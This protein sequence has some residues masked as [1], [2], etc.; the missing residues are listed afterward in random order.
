[1]NPQDS[2]GVPARSG[3][4]RH[5]N[6]V[7]LWIGE[8]TSG[9][10]NSLATLALPLI[11]VLSLHSSTFGSRWPAS[12]AYSAACS[13]GRPSSGSAPPDRP[14]CPVMSC[15]VSA[16]PPDSRADMIRFSGRFAPFARR[17]RDRRQSEEVMLK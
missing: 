3:L 5:G 6:F 9:L 16:A 8:T 7:L 4:F 17:D 1:M 13:S 11:A 14:G 12:A 15:Q 10:G 2:D